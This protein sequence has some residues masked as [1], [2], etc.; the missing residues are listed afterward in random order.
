M[1]TFVEGDLAFVDYGEMPPC[2]HTRLIGPHLTG[3]I[4]T[5]ITPDLDIYEE[6]LHIRNTDLVAMHP[7]L[8]GLGSPLPAGLNP[9]DVYSFG[10]MTAQQYQALMQRARLYAA[11]Y[12]VQH[13]LPPPGLHA[14]MPA[15]PA[16]VPVAPKVWV[17]LEA[18]FGKQI[19]DVICD[20]NVPLPAGSVTLGPSKA[21][22]PM[23]TGALAVKQV[24]KGDV[25][26][27]AVKDLRTLPLVFDQQGNRRQ[28]F[29][30]V[31]GRMTQ[32]DMPGGGMMLDGPA[33]TLGVLKSMVARGLTP[34]T[35]H[36]HWVRTHEL[37]RGDRSVYEMEVITRALEAF[38]MI[39]QLNLPNSKGIELLMR[40]WQLIREAHRISPGAPDY[41]S[42]DVF[43]GWEYKRGD[44]VHPE[45]ARFVAAELKDQ[46][47][48]A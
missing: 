23:G 2:I 4:Y 30:A 9:A 18:E 11:Q 34:V 39:D 41:S 32:D 37:P 27:M 21:L 12:R 26:S 28:D 20:E 33:S 10:P 6:E 35:D 7:G 24:S 17:S 44:G 5:I 16:Q 22:V 43:M 31:V 13:G 42:A 19:G 40:R 15:A 1:N 25:N 14:A 45:L 3:D 47:A 36:E 48:I 38:C 29:A 46:A 8:G